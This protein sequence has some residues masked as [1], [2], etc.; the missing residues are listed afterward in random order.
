MPLVEINFDG[1]VGPSHNYAG[2]SLGNLAATGNAGV[3]S[4]PREA[5]LEGVE[6]MR[7]NIRLGLTQGLLPP[8]DR[9]DDRWLAALAT[10]YAAAPTHLKAQALSAS[11]MWAANAATVS[12]A[13]D[14]AD[15]LCHLT[16]ANL[17]TMA[18]RSHEW[19]ETLAQLRLAFAD[20]AFL[21]HPPVPAPFALRRGPAPSP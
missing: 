14:A 17:V 18:H 11:P 3:T 6:K 16:V 2:L 5:A 20:P 1:V 10:D 15:G 8:H 19:P 13:P 12:P 4:R 21:V 7:A 9:P